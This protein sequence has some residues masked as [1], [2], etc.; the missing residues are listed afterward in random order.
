MFS[1]IAHWLLPFLQAFSSTKVLDV[2]LM[3]LRIPSPPPLQVTHWIP[4]D[5]FQG[6]ATPEMKYKA[7]AQLWQAG[8][9]V[10]TKK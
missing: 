5:Q 4:E 9:T 1:L 8:C 3:K 10:A 2:I 6:N 7:A